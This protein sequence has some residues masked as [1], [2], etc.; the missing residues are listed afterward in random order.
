MFFLDLTK[1]ETFRDLSKPIGALNK[2]RLDRLLVC[3]SWLFKLN[4]LG[5]VNIGNKRSFVKQPF[6]VN[7]QI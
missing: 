1:P 3:I 5:L 7:A 6:G 4:F 2:E